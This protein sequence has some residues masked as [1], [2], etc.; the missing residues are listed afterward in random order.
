MVRAMV[1]FLGAGNA[2][3]GALGRRPAGRAQAAGPALGVELPALCDLAPR[4]TG[5]PRRWRCRGRSATGRR[6]PARRSGCR[7]RRP[8][9]GHTAGAP[10]P[11]A[12]RGTVR[13]SSRP[14]RADAGRSGCTGRPG[15]AP[16]GASCFGRGRS[17]ALFRRSPRRKACRRPC[18]PHSWRGRQRVA[19]PG[20]ARRK[21]GRGRPGP[22]RTGC[23]DPGRCA[24]P[25][26]G[27][28]VCV[29]RRRP[30]PG[31]GAACLP[32]GAG[33]RGRGSSCSFSP[34]TGRTRCAPARGVRL[35]TADK[36]LVQ[37][38]RQY[39]SGSVRDPAR[40]PPPGLD[41]PSA[42]SIGV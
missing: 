20:T 27:R 22:C 29:R 3:C 10:P 39:A 13:R 17:F 24:S 7:A 8:A 31:R 36:D 2:P 19:S 34:H 5:W 21:R 33:R 12:C 11:G 35:R 23:R 28:I 4:A 32:P 16:S 30:S 25:S 42:P 37:G 38:V 9:V 14:Q 18:P 41:R 15:G 40:V 6:R 1:G 26:R